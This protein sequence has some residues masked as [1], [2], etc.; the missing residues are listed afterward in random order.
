MENKIYYV[1]SEEMSD[2][3]KVLEKDVS[4]YVAEIDGGDIHKSH[5][6]FEEISEKFN[7]PFPSRSSDSYNDWIRDLDWLNKDGYVLIINNYKSFLSQDLSFRKAVINGFNELI[8][9]WWGGEVAECVVGGK[10]K[11]FN[12]YLIE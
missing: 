4:L 1:S 12:V 7:F 5:D 11:S 8:L 3:K 9:P 10:T 2:I 6:F